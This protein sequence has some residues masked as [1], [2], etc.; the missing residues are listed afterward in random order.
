MHGPFRIDGFAAD[1]GHNA[2]L[3]TYWSDSNSFFENFD[4]IE[5]VWAFP[6]MDLI[7]TLMQFLD[8]RRRAQ[9]SLNIALLLPEHTNAPWFGYCQH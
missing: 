3:P 1:D 5:P 7:Q 4:G 2:Q 8:D 9:G 6:P